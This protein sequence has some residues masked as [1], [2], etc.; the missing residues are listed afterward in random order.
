MNARR[1]TTMNIGDGSGIPQPSLLRGPR[2]SMAP[3]MFGQAPS[4]VMK[5][6]RKS[7]ASGL[8]GAQTP[9][10][11]QRGLFGGNPPMSHVRNPTAGRPV[12]QTPATN[13]V[14]RRVS[15][16]ASSRRSTM[17]IAAP[18]TASRNGGGVKDPRPL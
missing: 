11:G 17:N 1:R 9:A 4:S 7:E 14:N 6:V 12:T 2:A 15:V 18:G 3:S 13:R 16:F 5:T 8:L 10:H